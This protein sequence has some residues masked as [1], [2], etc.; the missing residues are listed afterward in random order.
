MALMVRNSAVLIIFLSFLTTTFIILVNVLPVIL[1][2]FVILALYF[3]IPAFQALITVKSLV[4]FIFPII[5]S[6]FHLI[7]HL[8]VQIIIIIITEC[9][10]VNLVKY[11]IF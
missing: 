9:G 3:V 7:L 5:D 2:I 1:I 4:I 6:Q 8:V 11:S 10:K